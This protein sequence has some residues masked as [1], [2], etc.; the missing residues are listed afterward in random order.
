MNEALKEMKFTLCHKGVRVPYVPKED[1]LAEC[2]ELGRTV[3]SSLKDHM[4]GKEVESV[5]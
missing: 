1:Q 3:A 2:I 5:I 4:A